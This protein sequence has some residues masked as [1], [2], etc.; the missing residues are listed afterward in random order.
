[1]W[2]SGF[3]LSGRSCSVQAVELQSGRQKTSRLYSTQNSFM[4]SPHN[5]AMAASLLDGMDKEI[6]YQWLLAVHD[7]MEP[8]CSGAG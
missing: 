3:P 8:L 2:A 1:M 5:M 4:E 6:L 7:E